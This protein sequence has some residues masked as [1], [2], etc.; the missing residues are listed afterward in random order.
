MPRTSE[1]Q[2]LIEQLIQAYI[3]QLIVSNDSDSGNSDLEMDL[4]DENSRA[5]GSF[6][7]PTGHCPLQLRAVAT[8]VTLISKRVNYTSFRIDRSETIDSSTLYSPID[9]S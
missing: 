7:T 9:C 3:T 6:K 1:C 4:E 8:L 5:L 2:Q